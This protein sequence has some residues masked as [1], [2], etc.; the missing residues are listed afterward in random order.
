MKPS[1]GPSEV[2]VAQRNKP[3]SKTAP[4]SSAGQSSQ[5]SSGDR[6]APKGNCNHCGT[7]GHY[8]RICPYRKQKRAKAVV[9]VSVDAALTPTSAFVHLELLDSALL[10]DVESLALHG[11]EAREWIV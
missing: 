7:P 9:A 1:D 4:Y 11:C 6:L 3:R 2:L 8:W 10:S 5:D